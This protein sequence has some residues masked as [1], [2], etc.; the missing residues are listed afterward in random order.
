ML[1]V[2]MVGLGSWAR[3]MVGS[4]QGKSSAINFVSAYSRAPSKIEP[5][6]GAH[7]IRASDEEEEIGLDRAELGLEAYL[8]FSSS[9][10]PI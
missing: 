1:N 4:V 9:S 2:A 10:H 6:C 7:G 5:Y 8:E 3:R